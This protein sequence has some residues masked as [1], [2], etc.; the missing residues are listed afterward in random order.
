MDVGT[1]A[2]LLAA[3]PVPQI[4][5][6]DTIGSTNDEAL[7]WAA[8]GAVDG[9]LVAADQQTQGRGRMNRRWITRPGAA[10]AF[11]LILRPRLEEI[12]RMAFFSPLGALAICRALEDSLGL[13]PQIK[14]PNDVLLEGRKAAGILLETAWLGERSEGIVIGIGLNVTPA[15]VPPAGELLFPATSIEE[16]AGHP[17]DRFALLR[18][19]LWALF[20]WRS[21]LNEGAFRLAWEQRLAFRGEWVRIEGTGSEPVT[22]QVLGI[23]SSGGLLLRSSAGEAITITVGDVHLRL[24]E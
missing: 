17:V 13:A 16:A 9:C 2:S 23:D 1:L 11:S 14:W 19:I 15:S 18:E 10:L 5:S 21:R 4:R 3:L 7:S 12:G 22:G 24:M 8:A 6:F 20:A